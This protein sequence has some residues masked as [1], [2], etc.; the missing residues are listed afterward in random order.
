MVLP[1]GWMSGSSKTV[2]MPR[3]V[4]AM[5]AYNAAEFITATLDSVLANTCHDYEVWVIDDGS[6]DR[7]A[8][9]ASNRGARV[10]VVQQANRGMSASRNRAIAESDSEFVAL[11]DAD[12][13]WHPAKLALQL[14]VLDARP[15]VGLCYSEFFSWDGADAPAFAA[16]CDARL[17]EGLSG[18]LYPKM[19][20]TNFVLPSSA[21]FRRSAMKK[22]GPFLCDDQQTDDWEYMVRASRLFPFA[23]LA[24]PLVAYRQHA[25]S[26]SKRPR[27]ENVTEMMRESLIARF[28]LASPS[29]VAVDPLE[30]AHRRY[31]GWRN[32]AA[33]HVAHGSLGIGSAAFGKMLLQGPHRVDSALNF[34]KAL[35]R[36]LIGPSS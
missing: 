35:G 17:D 4:I 34:A 15:D 16:S 33:T 27:S 1:T 26:L 2:P 6:S 24:A 32:F 12:D 5:P 30:L 28:G 9:L 3:V 36:R 19:L 10:R 23:K 21:V 11:L 25:R 18:W 22:L 20:L 14:S 7:T 13:L 31:R 8:E 29:G